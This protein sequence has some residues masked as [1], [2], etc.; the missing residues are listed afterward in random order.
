MDLRAIQHLSSVCR[1]IAGSKQFLPLQDGL[2]CCSRSFKRNSYADGAF[3]SSLHMSRT[4]K[5]KKSM[6]ALAVC[7]CHMLESASANRNPTRTLLIDNYDSYTY[8]LYQLLAVINGAPPLVIKNDEVPWED[9]RRLL[10][11]ENAFDNIV[12]SPGPGSPVYAKDIGVCQQVLQECVKIPILGVCLGHQA[13]GYVN[14]AKV[15]HAPEPVHGRLSEV[16]HIDC[17]LFKDIPSGRDS[18]FQVVRYHSLI[19]DSNLPEDL[20]PTAWS[21]NSC[22]SLALEVPSLNKLEHAI[23]SNFGNLQAVADKISGRGLHPY[24]TTNHAPKIGCE[25]GDIRTCNLYGA[26]KTAENSLV[27]DSG[28]R[29]HASVNASILA[30]NNNIDA[31]DD[32]SR[33]R[34]VMAVSHRK[35]PHYGVQF[36]PESVATKFGTQILKNFRDITAMHWKEKGLTRSAKDENSVKGHALAQMV[37][38]GPAFCADARSVPLRIYWEKVDGIA[39]EAGGSEGIFCGL[40]GE[41]NVKDTFWLDSS[42]QPAG[43]RFSF[44]GR[45][46][47]RLW[48]RLSYSMSDK[49]G[50]GGV[51]KVEG[52]KGVQEMRLE[53]GFL[54]FLSSDLESYTISD[55]DSEGLPF[56]FWGGYVGYL[57]YELKAEC[58][59]RF[60][61]H[62]SELPDACY[63]FIDHFV[64]VDHSNHDVYAVVLYEEN[65]LAQME[66]FV[67]GTKRFETSSPSKPLKNALSK[68]S[69]STSTI[70]SHSSTSS[71]SEA[72]H[73][74]SARLGAQFWV[75]ETLSRVHELATEGGRDISVER[76]H[77]SHPSFSGISTDGS[78]G[79]FVLEKSQKQYMKDVRA[80]QAYIRDGE[81]YELCLTTQLRKRISSPDALGLYLT[82]RR[83]N[84]APYA[85]WLNFGAEEVCVCCSSPERFLRLDQEGVIEA[86]PIKGTRPRGRSAAEDEALKSNLQYSKKDQA[87][88]LMIVDLLRN[89]LGRVCEPGSVHVPKLMAVESYATVHSMVSTVR[90]LKRSD[91]TSIQ[92]V[93]ASF[94]GGS[95]TGAPKLRSMELLD[96]L[97]CTARG[98]YSGSIGFLSVNSTFDLNIVIRTIVLHEGVASIG[99]GGAIIAL[100][101]PQDEYEEMLLKTKAPI[102]AIA[103]H[104]SITRV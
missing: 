15:I 24:K 100:S 2:H 12:I 40:F 20:I 25:N 33:A 42:L 95:M 61:R 30:E 86:K 98:V 47:G 31:I 96:S 66:R 26:R 14:G 70:D 81:S 63:F 84:P 17:P 65:P 37:L 101:N 41:S 90:G 88:N 87:E 3:V 79:G 34:V 102:R 94:P 99:A 83:M 54:E 73:A 82:L 4:S 19:L 93:R 21:S 27:S 8:N 52:D 22:S 1:P 35:R 80:C 18:G 89:D 57:G 10:L 7:F 5:R 103:H 51:L 71:L 78:S 56:D 49:C 74:S 104:E 23:A 60:N 13:L 72:V 11:E 9:L 36:H 77:L 28:S 68:T 69:K 44:M 92:C 67:I 76:S 55:S 45:K 58:G 38:K 43:A 59:A 29:A 62:K 6:G 32:K 75:K 50:S 85:A 46:G 16:E 48:K 64:A 97:E 91:V 53:S 39:I